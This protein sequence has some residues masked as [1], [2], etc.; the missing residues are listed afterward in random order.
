MLDDAFF[1]EIIDPATGQEVGAGETGE[2]VVTTLSRLGC[3]LLRYRTGDQVRKGYTTKA[4]LA[5]EGGVLGRL[6]DMVQIRGVNIF[7]SAVEAIIHSVE[8]V[9][10]YQVKE[11]RRGALLELQVVVEPVRSLSPEQTATL[12]KTV[13]AKLRNAFSL[14]IP[15]SILASGELP[16]FEFKARRWIKEKPRTLFSV[17]S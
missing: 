1:S 16:R 7:P 14:R 8:G 5:L 2:L 17:D 6:D 12:A 10:E 15:V 9:G 4:T 11:K 13:A 3:P